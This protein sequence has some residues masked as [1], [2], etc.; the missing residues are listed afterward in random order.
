MLGL[1]ILRIPGGPCKIG[2]SRDLQRRLA[3]M[4]CHH[5][6][7]L[8]VVCWFPNR[9]H[10]EAAWHHCFDDYR[11][12]GEWFEWAPAIERAIALAEAG[13]DWTEVA[14]APPEVVA[15]LEAWSG[16]FPTAEAARAA[17]RAMLRRWAEERGKGIR[18]TYLPPRANS[19]VPPKSPGPVPAHR[20][21]ATHPG[22]SQ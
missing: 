21:G 15:E 5:P 13:E 1:Y 18:E 19:P 12:R 9:G 16:P 11:I 3:E 14:E 8:E 22:E 2:R 6:Y 10:E 20:R 7:N 4:Q 17:Y